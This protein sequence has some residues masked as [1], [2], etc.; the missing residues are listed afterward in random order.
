V[1][2]LR[3]YHSLHTDDWRGVESDEVDLPYSIFKV[4]IAVLLLSGMHRY[5]QRCGMMT[6]YS[7]KG[8]LGIS[9]VMI[10]FRDANMDARNET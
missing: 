3:R 4:C 7:I 5:E 2:E 1:R 9:R 6:Y 10:D 8:T